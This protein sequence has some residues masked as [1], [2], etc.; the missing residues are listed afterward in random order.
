MGKHDCVNIFIYYY[1]Y[2]F[3][4]GGGGRL[5]FYIGLGSA[6]IRGGVDVNSDQFESQDNSIFLLLT[7]IYYEVQNITCSSCYLRT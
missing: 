7:S 1:F 5:V 4:G 3:L 2:F 6:P